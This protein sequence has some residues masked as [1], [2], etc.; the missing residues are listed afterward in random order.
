[1][2]SGGQKPKKDR[3]MLQDRQNSRDGDY[4]YKSAQNGNS[5]L[6]GPSPNNLETPDNHRGV[7]PH[8]ARDSTDVSEYRNGHGK[9][10]SA[11]GYG[12]NESQH[13]QQQHMQQMH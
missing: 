12:S 11:V 3:R 4:I 5:H 2:G 1:M 6:R 7:L 9:G 10:V 13:H 8:I